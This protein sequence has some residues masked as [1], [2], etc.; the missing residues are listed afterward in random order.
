MMPACLVL[1]CELAF[2]YGLL[3]DPLNRAGARVGWWFYRRGMR[4]LELDIQLAE[5]AASLAALH[6]MVSAATEQARDQQNPALSATE[7]AVRE[8]MRRGAIP[9]YREWP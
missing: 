2:I 1:A 4:R 9:V 3:G 5:M 7:R 8:Q 6:L